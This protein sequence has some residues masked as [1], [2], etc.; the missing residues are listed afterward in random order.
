MKELKLQI[1]DS[2]LSDHMSST[3]IKQVNKIEK[4][5]IT[6]FKNQKQRFNK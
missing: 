3:I 6:K 4:L 5:I 2:N 1:N